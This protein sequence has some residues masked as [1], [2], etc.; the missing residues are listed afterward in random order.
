MQNLTERY[1]DY[2]T[3][4]VQ[5]FLQK[6]E[7]QTIPEIR[8]MPE[9]FLPLF[10]KDYEQSALRIIF[11]GQDTNWW[12]DLREFI[13]AEKACAGSRLRE[14]LDQFRE[15]PFTQS[16]KTRYTFWGFVMMTI[17]A[18]HGRKD[19]QLMKAGAMVEILNSIAWGNA[20]A[21]EFFES[22]AQKKGVPEQFWNQVRVAGEPL[23]RFQHVVQTLAPRVVV[24]LHQG[25]NSA[26][27]FGE[28][29]LE[30]VSQ[31]DGITHYQL[32]EIQIDVFQMPHPVSMKFHQGA[33][34]FCTKLAELLIA[35]KLAP[36]FQQFLK[37]Q[38]ETQEVMEFLYHNAPAQG[39]CDKFEFV[40]WV[41]N[42]LTKHEAFMSIPAL[43]E[44]LN[45][46]GYRTN[47]GTEYDAGR[48]S[49]RLVRSAYYRKQN[50][51]ELESARNIAISFRR[52][53]FQYAYLTDSEETASV[54]HD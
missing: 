2:Y 21:I 51:G 49:Y 3:P 19:W 39:G 32:P 12:W 45:K 31:Q 20:N 7:S 40:A 52:P 26:T 15:R 30:K 11:I 34:H 5:T 22:S 27:Y 38:A 36:R 4:L 6:L 46:Q 1:L 53:N 17:A 29:R 25:L 43:C 37:G 48:G 23:N 8:E 41:A 10:G 50:K 13:E 47:Y 16:G 35:R 24:L 44:L 54:N 18:L 28:Y 33:D 9:P 14:L 42:E